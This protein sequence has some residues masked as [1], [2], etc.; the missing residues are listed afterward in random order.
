MQSEGGDLIGCNPVT[1]GARVLQTTC[2][3]EGG[4]GGDLIGCNPDK[5]GARV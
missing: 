1:R 3:S 2:S 4:K 5:R